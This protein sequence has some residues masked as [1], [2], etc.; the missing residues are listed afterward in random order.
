MSAKLLRAYTRAG[1]CL[2]L[3]V[4][5]VIAPGCLSHAIAIPSDHNDMKGATSD[6]T[7]HVNTYSFA[8]HFAMSSPLW[9]D[10]TLPY[11]VKRNTAEHA[12]ANAKRV[13]IVQSSVYRYWWILPP[14]SFLLTPVSTNVASN[15]DL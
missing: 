4:L 7:M 11:V 5:T 15:G 12:A 3:A 6:S 10:A 8:L 9:G 2:C 13:H 14:F 1:L